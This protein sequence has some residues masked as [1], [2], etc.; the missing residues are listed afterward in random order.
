MATELDVDIS[1]AV[2]ADTKEEE[3]ALAWR[4]V[5]PSG[6]DY[7]CLSWQLAAPDSVS[8][9][10]IGGEA[11]RAARPLGRADFSCT[12][13]GIANKFH[14]ALSNLGQGFRADLERSQKEASLST[15]TRD[16]DPSQHLFVDVLLEWAAKRVQ[17]GKSP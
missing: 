8:A 11:G 12:A 16:L 10:A 4:Q 14:A 2:E 7:S 13:T 6:V 15:R 5:N 9:E 17:W 1:E 3:E